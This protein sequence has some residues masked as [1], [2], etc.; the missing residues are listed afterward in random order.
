LC[1]VVVHYVDEPVVIPDGGNHLPGDRAC[2][3][4]PCRAMQRQ[5][6]G[7]RV[8]GERGSGLLRQALNEL[9]RDPRRGRGKPTC[10]RACVR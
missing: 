9:R 10:V 7:G 3:A 8:E 1:K 5:L 4:E 2:H 6:R